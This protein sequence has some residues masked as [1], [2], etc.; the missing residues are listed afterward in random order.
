LDDVFYEFWTVAVNAFP[1]LRA[2][3]AFIGDTVAAKTVLSDLWLHIG[4][5]PAGRQSDK[6][7]PVSGGEYDAESEEHTS[8]LQSRVALVSRLAPS[9]TVCHGA[10]DARPCLSGALA[11]AS[12]PNAAK[13][14]LAA[15]WAHGGTA[16]P[17]G[18]E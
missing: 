18:R 7:H 14:V 3:D 6:Q 5:A 8:E 12:W 16:A 13:S 10:H 2:A 11:E 1:F 15:G 4:K 9:D 17:G